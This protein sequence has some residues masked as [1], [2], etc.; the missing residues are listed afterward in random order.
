LRNVSIADVRGS[1]QKG[2]GMT[3]RRRVLSS[4]VG[5]AL[6]T[7]IPLLDHGGEDQEGIV[8]ARGVP[9]LEKKTKRVLIRK[10]Y[11]IRRRVTSD[12]R[13]KGKSK[14]KETIKETEKGEEKIKEKIGEELAK[15]KNGA[16]KLTSWKC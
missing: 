5:G 16:G 14:R 6:E 3:L 12:G 2:T 8:K 9:L 7:V 4:P 10:E 13:T 11:N 15:K 1:Y